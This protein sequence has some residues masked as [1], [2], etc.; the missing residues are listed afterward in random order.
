M[1]TRD[2]LAPQPE[3][4]RSENSGPSPFAAPLCEGEEGWTERARLQ[5]EEMERVVEQRTAELRQG[6]ERFAAAF[7][8]APLPQAIL[9]YATGQIVDVN[10]AFSAATGFDKVEVVAHSHAVLQHTGLITPLRR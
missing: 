2:Q 3:S 4:T 6:E 8:A 1:P 7:R 10:E 5:M 9:N